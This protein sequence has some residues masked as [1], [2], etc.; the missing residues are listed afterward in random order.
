MRAVAAFGLGLVLLCACEPKSNGERVRIR[1]DTAQVSSGTH[2]DAPGAPAGAHWTYDDQEHWGETC[3][4]GKTQSPVALTLANTFTDLPD[5]AIS[6]PAGDGAFLDNGHTLQFTPNGAG[7]LKIGDDSYKLAQFHFHAPSEHTLDGE[8]FPVELHF[9]N[10]NAAGELAV[11]GVFIKEGAV[12]SALAALLAAL[13]TGEGD[14]HI[15]HLSVDPQQLLP[16]SRFY[17]T[18]GGSLTTP[19]CSEGVR[20][21]VL[22][23]PVGASAEQIKALSAALGH[24]NR[25]VQALNDRAIRFGR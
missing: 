22:A 3:P 7:E 8:S 18:Y 12:N 10:K 25:L 5:L 23:A 1:L 9:V 24:S 17:L 6:Y 16:K 2:A 14:E 4:T 13:P 11:V 19:P 15:T 20:W 21:N